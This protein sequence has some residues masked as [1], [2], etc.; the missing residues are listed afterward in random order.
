MLKLSE[1]IFTPKARRIFK[2]FGLVLI[3]A[4]LFMVCFVRFKRVNQF[5]I[6]NHKSEPFLVLLV[7][8]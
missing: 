7:T 1:K 4:L 5:Y 8:I 2:Y 6:D 3:V